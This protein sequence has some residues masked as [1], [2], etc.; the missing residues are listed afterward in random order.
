MR[1]P[2]Q[3]EALRRAVGMLRLSPDRVAFT[4]GGQATGGLLQRR[5]VPLTSGFREFGRLE[6]SP[7]IRTSCEDIYCTYT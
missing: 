7:V 2:G 1:R 6:R 4:L 3:S 5:R